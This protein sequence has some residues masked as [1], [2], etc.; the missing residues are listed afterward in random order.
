MP[1]GKILR[2]K[3]ESFSIRA[4]SDTQAEIILYGPIGGGGWFSD[5]ITATQFSKELQKLDKKTK[6]ITVRINS[7]GGDVFDGIAIYNRLK[8]HPAKVKCIV[9]GLAASIA[10]IIAL[11]GDEVIMGEGALYM[12]HLPWSFAQGNRNDFE[13]T[14]QRLMDVEEQMIGIYAKRTK[15]SR[16]EIRSMLEKETWL[17]AQ[18]A[19][20]QGFVDTIEG[21]SLPIAAQALSQASWIHKAPEIKTAETVVKNEIENLKLRI[22]GFLDRK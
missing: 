3:N 6:E 4:Q 11:G 10:S 18:E 12:V 9:D 2:L 1:N 17:S 14:I 20:D 22:S 7:P 8:Q 15:L 13:N 16:A 21:D 5:G 19:K